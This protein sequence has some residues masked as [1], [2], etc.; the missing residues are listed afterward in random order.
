MFDIM[1]A[2]DSFGYI[3]AHP[4]TGQIASYGTLCKVIDRRML[5]DGRHLISVVG[6]DRFRLQRIERT[7]PYVMAEVDTNVPDAPVTDLEE[8]VSLEKDVYN[9][10]KFHFRLLRLADTKNSLT[11]QPFIKQ[12]RPNNPTFM[13]PAERRTRF[14]FALAN[15]IAMGDSVLSQLVLQT[16]DVKKRL[17]LQR[18]YLR[19]AS[20]AFSNNLIEWKIITPETCQLIKEKS[21]KDDYDDDILP[22]EIITTEEPKE[23]DEW[24]LQNVM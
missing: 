24:D 18:H 17:L 12:F 3:H 14:S 1:N 10:L 21:F 7:L 6:V 23:K 8:I 2:D 13:D 15:M 19:E 9:Y 22:H 20:Q 11:V 4:R 5:E 16:T